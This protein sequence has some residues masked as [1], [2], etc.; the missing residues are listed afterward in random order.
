MKRILPNSSSPRC[1]SLLTSF[2]LVAL[3]SSAFAGA[4]YQA[5]QPEENAGPTSIR[6]AKTVLRNHALTTFPGQRVAG[7][8]SNQNR[9]KHSA[10]YKGLAPGE[11]GAPVA[12]LRQLLVTTDQSALYLSFRLSQPG[13]RAPPASA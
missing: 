10:T 13:G 12:I 9:V 8:L 1:E 6:S 2:L 11:V 3:F 7:D 4:R 5:R